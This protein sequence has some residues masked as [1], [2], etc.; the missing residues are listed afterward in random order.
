M[1][2]NYAQITLFSLSETRAFVLELWKH[3][4]QLVVDAQFSAEADTGHED[5][6]KTTPAAA[7]HQFAPERAAQQQQRDSAAAARVQALA[8]ANRLRFLEVD[9]AAAT[10]YSDAAA[11]A[12][13]S[14]VNPRTARYD[15]LVKE[16][17]ETRA[18]R[19]WVAA[20]PN[21]QALDELMRLPADART[22]VPKV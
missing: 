9:R 13:A 4:A 21:A 3:L 12:A 18:A 7:S 8:R 20:V 5:V 19:G 15:A 22:I 1:I 10:A 14:A 16:A 17:A 6:N 2:C 11:T